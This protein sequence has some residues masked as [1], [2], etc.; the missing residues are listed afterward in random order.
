MGEFCGPTEIGVNREGDIYVVDWGGNRV[1]RFRS[2]DEVSTT[3][4]Q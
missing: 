1:Q 4:S 3:L 2:S